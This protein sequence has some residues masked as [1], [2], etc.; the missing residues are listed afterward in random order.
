M[1]KKNKN[2][3]T[4]RKKKKKEN[5]RKDEEDNCNDMLAYA[6]SETKLW[7]SSSAKQRRNPCSGPP[8]VYQDLST[9]HDCSVENTIVNLPVRLKRNSKR[10]SC[11]SESVGGAKQG[12]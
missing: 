7:L 1:Q 10:I 4:R 6:T 3:K 8:P 9:G 5:N 12:F 2:R 11:N